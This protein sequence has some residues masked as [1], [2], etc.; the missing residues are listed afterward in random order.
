MRAGH[1]EYC[2]EWGYNMAQCYYEH[3]NDGL[4]HLVYS[5]SL[6]GTHPLQQVTQ[7]VLSR[8]TIDV[9]LDLLN[10]LIP[11]IILRGLV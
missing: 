9:P 8:V 7:L 5:I 10:H 3:I 1:N 6:D 4:T 2:I 11:Q